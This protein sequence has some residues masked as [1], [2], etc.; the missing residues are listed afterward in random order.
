MSGNSLSE[1]PIQMDLGV[2]NASASGN[3]AII[4]YMSV[5]LSGNK[6]RDAFRLPL[7]DRQCRYRKMTIFKIGLFFFPLVRVLIENKA[8]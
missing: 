4:F 2:Q 3:Y 1:K 8:K 7:R 6:E 5:T